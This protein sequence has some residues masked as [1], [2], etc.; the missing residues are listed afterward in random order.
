MHFGALL[1]SRCVRTLWRAPIVSWKYHSDGVL[2]QTLLVYKRKAKKGTSCQRQKLSLTKNLSRRRE[3]KKWQRQM[4]GCYCCYYYDKRM[5]GNCWVIIQPGTQ[6]GHRMFRL[7][8]LRGENLK[9]IP[10][11]YPLNNGHQVRHYF[12][13]M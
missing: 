4:K 11:A 13:E 9:N 1:F 10:K 12:D 5:I 6:A 2:Y 8:L 7:V 3:V